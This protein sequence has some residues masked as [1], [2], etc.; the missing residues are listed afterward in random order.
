MAQA[1]RTRGP[2]TQGKGDGSGAMSTRPQEL[3]DNKVLSNRDKAQHN[4]ERGQDGKWIDSEQRYE[5]DHN[6]RS[7]N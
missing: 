5:T 2:G 1:G 6:R 4:R 3:P 7:E